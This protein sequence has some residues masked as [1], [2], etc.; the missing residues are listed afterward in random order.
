MITPVSVSQYLAL[1]GW[2]KDKY[3]SWAFLHLLTVRD[4]DFL[5]SHVGLGNQRGRDE[6]GTAFPSGRDG[7]S[8]SSDSNPRGGF[9]G[10]EEDI[11]LEKKKWGPIPPGWGSEG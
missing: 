2:N 10:S 4:L 6:T 5:T 1:L 3:P 11:G 8:A 7:V 9:Q